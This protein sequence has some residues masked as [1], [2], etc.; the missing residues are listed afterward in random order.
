M[1][2]KDCGIIGTAYF[3]LHLLLHMYFS[4]DQK[5]KTDGGE[6]CS[7]SRECKGEALNSHKPQVLGQYNLQRVRPPPSKDCTKRGSCKSANIPLFDS[8]SHRAVSG[9]WEG[10]GR[11][12]WAA[13][14]CCR[15]YVGAL[16]DRK[17]EIG[18]MHFGFRAEIGQQEKFA[19]ETAKQ[20]QKM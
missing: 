18:R 11:L 4:P 6:V 2:E 9:G 13:S 16:E 8:C 7:I 17:R 5:T 1:V 20:T 10:R 12:G 15:A 3:I 14:S 19:A